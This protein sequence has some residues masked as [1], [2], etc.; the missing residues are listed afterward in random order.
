MYNALTGTNKIAVIG[1]GFILRDGDYNS[2]EEFYDA[3]IKYKSRNNDKPTS[4][5]TP[6]KT[7]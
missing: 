5:K 3:Y 1:Q 6:N 4:L 7:R 2:F